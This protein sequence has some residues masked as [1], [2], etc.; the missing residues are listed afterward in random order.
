[1][2]IKKFI[3]FAANGIN[4]I[5]AGNRLIDQVNSLDYFDHIYLYT[6]DDLIADDEFWQIHSDFI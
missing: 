6:I 1:M 3:T 4:Y 5:E 2:P